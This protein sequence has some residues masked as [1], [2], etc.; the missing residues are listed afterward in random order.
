METLS[1]RLTVP[2]MRIWAGFHTFFVSFSRLTVF[3]DRVNR[4]NNDQTQDHQ[5][6][7]YRFHFNLQKFA[8]LPGW[9]ITL[10]A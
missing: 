7:K 9:L 6:E 4:K 8:A 2:L 5:C 1:F 3:L 10:P